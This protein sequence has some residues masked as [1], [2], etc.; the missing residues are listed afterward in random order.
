VALKNNKAE[1]IQ[2]AF[3]SILKKVIDGNGKPWS[4]CQMD[5]GTEFSGM[6]NVDWGQYKGENIS[7]K[8]ICL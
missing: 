7:I 1:T 6:E 4:V 8:F 2:V 5:N 3:K